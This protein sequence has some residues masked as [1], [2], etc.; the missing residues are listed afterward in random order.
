MTDQTLQSSQN[1]PTAIE[2]AVDLSQQSFAETLLL[3]WQSVLG[4]FKTRYVNTADSLLDEVLVMM[5]EKQVNDAL[6]QFVT[7]NVKMILDLRMDLNDDWL[8]LYCTV[9]FKG[10]FASVACNFRLAKTQINANTQLF[11]FEQLSDTEILTL[12]SKK[13][14]HATAIRLGL[15]AYRTIKKK[16]PLP[17]ILHKIT[18][19]NEPFAT[20]EGNFIYLDIHRYLAKQTKILNYLKKAQINDA[21]TKLHKLLLKVEPNFAEIFSFGDSGEDIITERD[22]PNRPK[23]EKK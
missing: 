10:I 11:V 1:T 23:K 17:E 22:N 20:Y 9:N 13:W 19:K 16:D 3:T 8:R 4:D 21:N 5:T 7:K 14:W 15:K 6:A 18:V 2:V 12:H